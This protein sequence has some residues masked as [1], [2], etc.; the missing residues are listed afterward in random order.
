MTRKP[1][2]RAVALSTV[3]IFG[4]GTAALAQ[5]AIQ[6]SSTEYDAKTDFYGR[7][8]NT[9]VL[10]RQ[11]PDYEALGI[12]QGGM[13]IYP[14][15]EVGATYD[16][17]VFATSNHTKSDEYLLVKPSIVAESNWGR[18]G[19]RLS[20]E[21][22]NEDYSRF[23]TENELGYHL[24]A[25]GRIDVHGESTINMGLLAD[26]Q[27]EARGNVYAVTDTVKP[28]QFDS[29]GVYARGTYVQDRI[30]LTLGGEAQNYD[31]QNVGLIGGGFVDEA[32]RNAHSWDANARVD[33]A[34]TP[35]TAVFANITEG[36]TNY[37]EGAPNL[38]RDSGTTE[39]LGGVNFDI[40]ALARGEIGIGY[41][42]RNYTSSAYPD[43]S[44]LS[45]GAK[46][47]Y[48]PTPLLTVTLLAQRKPQDA[49]FITAS[50]FISSSTSI[51]ADYEVR[52]N[53][54]AS[55]TVGYEKDDF[56]GVDRHD[57][58]TNLTLTSRYYVTRTIG[59][60]ANVIYADRSSAGAFAGPS[61]KDTQVGVFLV[62]QR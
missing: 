29:Q 30:R 13:T 34:L 23:T 42:D 11:R 5:T 10:E 39:V 17:N 40:T 20:A 32:S 41:F 48:F 22:D 31:Y 8:K 7:G 60:G 9:S 21:L 12:Q 4:C 44:G 16:D 14:T 50:G 46:L 51:G 38:R 24:H 36:G 2:T 3:A 54:I 52:R 26:R 18:H 57:Q 61:Y 58:V 62:F 27:Y 47:E 45:A 49:A 1:F 56:E 43:F 19:L 25:D 53:W 15:V 6:P 55:A 59:V 33:Y 37:L 28:V 35:D